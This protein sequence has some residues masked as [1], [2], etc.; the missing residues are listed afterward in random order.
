M[1]YAT[2]HGLENWHKHMFEHLGWMILA[3]DNGYK[4]KVKG[5]LESIDHL[6]NALE[7]RLSLIEEEDRKLDMKILLHNVKILKKNANRLL[8]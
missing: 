4:T 7:E 5:Y 3:K 8:K 6:E 1:Y 2:N